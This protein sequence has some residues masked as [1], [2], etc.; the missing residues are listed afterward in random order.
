[1]LS[2]GPILA[3]RAITRTISLDAALLQVGR[4]VGMTVRAVRLPFADAAVD[5]DKEADLLLANR[6]LAERQ[7]R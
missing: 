7:Q 3:L 2:F 4:R 5:V 1:M 6:I